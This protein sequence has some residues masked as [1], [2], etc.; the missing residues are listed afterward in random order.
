MKALFVLLALLLSGRALASGAGETAA[1]ALDAFGGPAAD[2]A[3]FYG[4]GHVGVLF[5]KSPFA[6][7]FAAW[8]LLHGLPVGLEAGAGL[9]IPCCGA[10][11]VFDRAESQWQDDRRTVG[12]ATD[13]AP[14]WEYR[15]GA[16]NSSVRTCFPDAFLTASRTLRDRVATYGMS[17]PGVHAW[18]AGQDVVFESCSKSP[19]MP[20]LPDGAPDWLVKD[21]DY[22]LAAKALYERRFADA[23]ARFAAIADDAASVWRP[24]GPY[25]AARAALLA[26]TATQDPALDAAARARLAGLSG[27]DT[28][29]H[30]AAIPLAHALDLRYRPDARRAELIAE[31]TGPTLT[32]SAAADF[33][34]LRLLGQQPA[35]TPELLDWLT[36]YGR[37]PDK[38][39]GAW[40]D[41]YDQEMPW[42]KDADALAQARDRWAAGHDP[43]WLLAAL[44]WSA[45]GPAA[46]DLVAAARALPP[47]HPAYLTAAYHRLR[48]TFGAEPA[49]Q[50]A[51]LDALLARPDQ[52]AASRNVFLAQRAM[53]AADPADFARFAVRTQPCHN[54]PDKSEWPASP[55]ACP[56]DAFGIDYYDS[57]AGGAFGDDAL[58]TIDRMTLARRTALAEDQRLPAP[59]R[60]DVALT[61][62]TRA[63]LAGDDPAADRLAGDLVVLLPQMAP[64]WRRFAATAP[65]VDKRFA[66]WFA[67][68]KLPGAAVDLAEDGPKQTRPDELVVG[69]YVRPA[70]TVPEFEGHWPDWRYV[71][72]DTTA[73]PVPV[74]APTIDVVCHSLCG[75]GAFPYR[76]PDF[77]TAELPRAAQERGHYHPAAASAGSVWEEVLAYARA[78][79]ADARSPEALYWLVRV[80]RFG[81]GH[82]RSSYRAW[83]LLHQRYRDST[84]AKSAPYFYD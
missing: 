66:A 67:L 8:R 83:T 74:P 16:D 27:V 39:E 76:A 64:E 13:A 36:V 40:F 23:E 52:L 11:L 3:A 17:D 6:R 63:A 35:G 82:A 56:G 4:S 61:S 78:H 59:L 48:L 28:P 25:L 53:L 5:G 18:L 43:A 47:D 37:K 45:P 10:S 22:Q 1:F 68:A 69:T 33:K 26:A 71:A 12:G 32:A 73:K 50:R 2:Q 80:G 81:L 9:T 65:G 29:G 21:R 75:G 77:V 49:A 58:R 42:P 14:I 70:G 19:A 24:L 46:K 44:E 20:P 84:W 34:D 54:E 60:L 79:P 38:A 55:A 7:L 31:L 30:G 62:W 72:A 51:E 15:D 57:A 41:H